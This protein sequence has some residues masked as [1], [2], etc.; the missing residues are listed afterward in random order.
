MCE[1]I[2]RGKHGID[3]GWWC[4]AGNNWQLLADHTQLLVLA[5]SFL[6]GVVLTLHGGL[7]PHWH[8]AED[9]LHD[10]LSRHTLRILHT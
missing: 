6:P 1:R 7:S 4:N 3:G 5:R 2:L 9:L 8:A 10:L